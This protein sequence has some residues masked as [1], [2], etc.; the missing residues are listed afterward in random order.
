[1][2]LSADLKTLYHLVLKPVRGPTHAARME[3]FYAGQAEDYDRFRRRLLPGR[4]ELWEAIAAPTGGIWVDMGGGTGG[5]LE[6][7]GP[8][9]S[10]LA[11][12]YLVD[13]SASMLAVARER[14][15]RHGWQNVETVEADAAG[16][17]PPE[18]AADVVTFSY[19]LTMIPDW[20]AAVE[21][22]LAILSPGGQIGVVDFYV[23]RRDPP[24]GWTRHSRLAR[25][26]WPFWFARYHVFPSADHAPL[27]HRRF[28]PVHFVEG[29]APVPY[30]PLIRLPYYRFVG[31]KR[32]QAP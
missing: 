19:S 2:Q 22:A 26:F 1:M 14:I 4:R 23:A 24:R 16:Y 7:L 5:N 3:S 13:L 12:I 6:Y 18:G 17:R 31:R 15:Y 25:W 29:R 21:N 27:L 28:E 9:I 20:S 32:G 30:A 8:R 11:K 10:D